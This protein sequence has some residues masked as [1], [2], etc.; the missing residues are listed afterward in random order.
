[1]PAMT[2]PSRDK[3]RR[4]VAVEPHAALSTERVV[5]R[6]LGYGDEGVFLDALERSRERIRRWFPIEHPGETPRSYLRRLV[7]RGVSADADGSACR[8]AV[9]THGGEFVGMVN[10]IKIDRGMSWNAEINAWIGTD[11]AGRGLGAHAVGA[12]VDHA[13]GE[14]P[15]GL[16]LHEVRAWACLDNAPSVR[17]LGRLGFERTGVAELLEVNAAL[18]RHHLFVRRTG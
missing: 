4:R 5:L 2:T 14:L 17:L 1:M 6:P 12:A 3:T 7:E 16:G 18:V 9:F 10:L 13:L 8:R 15:V 11:H